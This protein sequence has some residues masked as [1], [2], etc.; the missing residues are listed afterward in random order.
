MKWL[1]IM[2]LLAVTSLRLMEPSEP[3]LC[4]NQWKAVETDEF[5][6]GFPSRA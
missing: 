4:S 6:S 1:N 5:P 3:E 2:R